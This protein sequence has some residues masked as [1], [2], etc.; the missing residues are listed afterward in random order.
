MKRNVWIG[1]ALMSAAHL[2]A[3]QTVSHNILND[4]TVVWRI[5]EPEVRQ[6]ATDYPEILIRPGDT[7]IVHAEGCVQTGGH[8]KTWKRYVN[9]SGA[10]SDR[11]YHGQVS[12]PGGGTSGLVNLEAVNDKPLAVKSAP[13]GTDFATWYLRLG[14][15]DSDGDYGDNG[16]ADHDNGTDDQCKDVGAARVVITI[17]QHPGTPGVVWRPISARIRP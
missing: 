12:V 11:L 8:G 3:A 6:S 16:Y 14:Y 1:I 7:V 5:E 2:F 10:N 13:E 9:P 15:V 4:N 17:T